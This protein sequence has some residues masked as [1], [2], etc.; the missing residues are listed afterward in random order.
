MTDPLPPA[1]AEQGSTP[2]SCEDLAQEA[3]E[4]P[5]SLRLLPKISADALRLVWAANP[6]MLIASIALKLVNGAGLATALIFGK[7][8]IGSVLSTDTGS[9]ATAPGIGAVA[10]QL[11][12]VVGVV[13]ALGLVTAA[14]REVREILSE[15][16]ARHAKQAIIDVARRVELSAYETPSF[17]DRLVRA[18]AGEHRPIQMVDGLIGTIGAF[19]SIGGIVVALLAIQPWLVP[20]LFLA[21]LPLL[22]GVMKA[23]QAMFGFHMRMTT[24]ARRRNYLYRL[25]TE[26]D[27]AKE[28]RAF[29]LGDYL[30]NRHTVLYEQHMT[31]LRKTT[32]KRFRIAVA[33]TLGL[34]AALGA[35]MAG[36]LALALSGRLELAAAA[37]AAGALLILGE[38]IMTTVNSV[39]DMYESGLFVEDFTNFLAT[40]PITHGATGSQ[41][42]PATF[43]R[44]TIENVT[45]TY[46]AATT[47]A[48]RD[49]S[50]EIEA[51]QVIA[52]V[53][54]N[55]SGKT[56][57]AKL[58]SRLYLPDQGAIRWD[59][60]NTTD[61]N[62]DEVHRR[63]AVIFQDF[64]RYDL[65]AR[66]NIGLGAVDHI[67]DL[68][69]IETAA[70]HAGADRYLA[71][72][73][74]GYETILSPEYDGGR[75]LSVGQWQRVALA[76]A[77]IR[78]APL[79]I[80]D[81]PTASLDPRAEHDL[82]SR[83]RTLYAGRTV[84]LISHRYNTV[85]DADR[86]Y[87]LHRGR[88]IEHGSHDQL[89]AQA[90]TYAELFTLQAAA[91]TNQPSPN[92]HRTGE[93]LADKPAGPAARPRPD[94]R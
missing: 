54:E 90:G 32:R 19:A 7:N 30:T 51:G 35:G 74:A 39:G 57:L 56:T 24:A 21:G 67:D 76:R 78:D 62:A 50:V 42:A 15:T 23:G 70:R 27:P 87:V 16:T 37:T 65:T 6:R 77:F 22:A 9:A 80:L 71:A 75:D 12:A 38:R 59:G 81:E 89:I 72:L 36:L 69:A 33:S 46:P 45:F 91:Y 93:R 2:P 29:G 60:A 66:E 31:E 11:A 83:I 88:I 61:M 94:Q 10:P 8:L 14:G 58:L 47:P 1:S 44:I 5:R 55:G 92:G 43:E 3:A 34:A 4:R 28:V 18:A 53:G 68:A 82:F 20:L 26:K 73:P 41:P 86:I 52:L 13:A 49:V 84:L 48:L 79:I 85:R 40:A 63:I 64:A 25:L 17:H